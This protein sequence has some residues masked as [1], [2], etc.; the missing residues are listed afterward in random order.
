MIQH[1]M[2]WNYRDEVPEEERAR[3]ESAFRALPC[4]ITALNR[5]E[6]GPVVGGRN[7]SFSHCFVMHF[8][9]Q[10]AL[11]EYADNLEHLRV[12]APFKEACAAQV[13]IDFEEQ[14]G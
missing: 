5:V 3:L 11:A 4:K 13:A 1:I 12:A 6:L 2:L 7:Q 8:D 10:A 14:H 9:D